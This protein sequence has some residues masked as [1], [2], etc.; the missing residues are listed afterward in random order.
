MNTNK[1][2]KIIFA[3]LTFPNI[4][5]L[6]T[7]AYSSNLEKTVI[8]NQTGRLR[9]QYSFLDSRIYEVNHLLTNLENAKS[10]SI[11]NNDNKASDK[12]IISVVNEL[13]IESRIQ[14]EKDNILYANGDV[15]VKFKDNILKA[16]KLTY[17]K[18]TKL[19][20]AEGNIH[21]KIN[22]QIFQADMVEYDFAN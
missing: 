11:Y 14:S 13:L 17:N 2:Q 7:E 6:P 18:N 19:A 20:K 3:C 9:E 8:I 16:D 4:L 5:I 10:K 12:N 21:L 1:I 22:N 15:V